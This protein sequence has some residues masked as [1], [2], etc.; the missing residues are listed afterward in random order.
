MALVAAAPEPESPEPPVVLLLVAAEEAGAFC[1]AEGESTAGAEGDL[2][3]DWDG[4]EEGPHHSVA[5]GRT[6]YIPTALSC[7]D[8]TPYRYRLK[9]MLKFL[10]ASTKL[11]IGP[12]P[13]RQGYTPQ[14]FSKR[15]A[16]AT[17]KRPSL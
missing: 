13:A 5:A 12:R 14:R 17:A 15:P 8:A 1:A 6:S 9:G 7:G 11:A 16:L 10:D 3:E 2:S 4:F